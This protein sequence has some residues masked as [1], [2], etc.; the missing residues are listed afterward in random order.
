MATR[1]KAD[2]RPTKAF[3]AQMLAKDISLNAAILD[4]LDNSL[5]GARRL[6]GSE[7]LEGLSVEIMAGPD[8][9]QISDNC[10]GI[11]IEIA[12]HYAFRFG[13]T[14]S[15]HKKLDFE[16]ST[17]QFGVGMKRAI[18]KMGT[19]FE[20]KSRASD[21]IF[22]MDEDVDVWAATDEKDWTFDLLVEST[23]PPP[24]AERG[25]TI[26]IE[27]L[28]DTVAEDFELTGF[29]N[30]LE[31]EL[32]ERY[33]VPLERGLSI[34]FNGKPIGPESPMILTSKQ[35]A[36][37]VTSLAL[38]MFGQDA[39]DGSAAVRLK[40]LCGLARI[41]APDAGWSVAL[42]D[43]MVLL[44]DQTTTSGWGT[45]NGRRIP[46]FHGQYGRM[47]G[48]CAP[49]VR[50]YNGSALEHYENGARH[51]AGPLQARS[52]RDGR[53][54]GPRDQVPERSTN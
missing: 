24:K 9:F 25:T 30:E 4:L 12:R 51:W 53:G 33:V 1:R 50:A 47:R 45:R 34:R 32:A 2:A 19:G 21:G 38:D 52:A 13:R 8:R 36:P 39:S 23:K 7:S 46:G 43:R 54:H 41:E 37:T 18:F 11:P 17:G 22:S 5:D 20:I 14:A 26:T 35:L 16:H 48:D 29:L 44:A 40:L 3:F 6:R 42:N 28:H 10:G 31:T 49:R 27:P 15:A